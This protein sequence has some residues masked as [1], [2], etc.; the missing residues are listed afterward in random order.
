MPLDSAEG[1]RVQNQNFVSV[2]LN[3]D[4]FEGNPHAYLWTL[5]AHIM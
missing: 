2:W 4:Q 5:Y 1:V 3:F